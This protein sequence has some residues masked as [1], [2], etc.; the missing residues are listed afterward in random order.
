MPM[1]FTY[2]ILFLSIWGGGFFG[3]FFLLIRYIANRYSRG[4]VIE[5]DMP[6][7]F[8]GEIVLFENNIPR[9][10]MNFK[11]LKNYQKNQLEDVEFNNRYS[12][13]TTNQIEAR[14]VLTAAFIERLKNIKLKF[15]AN[16]IRLQFKNNKIVIFLGVDKDLFKMAED[17]GDTDINTFNELSEE[18]YSV[19]SLI[20]ELKLNIKTGL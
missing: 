4:L 17:K 7:R 16:S 2:A 12:I 18:I 20:D 6:K 14:Y 19:L 5:L 15:R 13:Y 8:N 11:L 1:F 10:I 3:P 9:N